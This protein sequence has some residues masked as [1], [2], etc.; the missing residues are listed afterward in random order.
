MTQRLSTMQ[1]KE[2]SL[3]P[4]PAQYD[5]GLGI[6]RYWYEEVFGSVGAFSRDSYLRLSFACFFGVY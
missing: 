4:C 1:V 3:F 6:S 5:V 2:V